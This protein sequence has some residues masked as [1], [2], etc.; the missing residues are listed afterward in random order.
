MEILGQSL[1]AIHN[2]KDLIAQQKVAEW[3]KWVVATGLIQ[4]LLSAAAL[5]WVAKTFAHT[6]AATR[7]ALES[8]ALAR[9]A[10]E[11]EHRPWLHFDELNAFRVRVRGSFVRVHLKVGF[12][13]Y[14]KTP[15]K[16]IRLHAK[17]YTYPLS[18]VEMMS[19]FEAYA[20]NKGTSAVYT[21]ASNA[22]LMEETVAVYHLA[23]H[24]NADPFAQSEVRYL[25]VF[26]GATYSSMMDSDAEYSTTAAMFLKFNEDMKPVV[27]RMGEIDPADFTVERQ[28]KMDRMS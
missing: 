12:I 22:K 28:L 25:V 2:Q 15:A 8:A 26:L 24:D 11:T 7:I 19:A 3:T 23:E 16:N 20:Q 1:E 9:S 5:I 14:G 27:A 6:S 21:L 17:A 10:Y 18:A 4:T 13:N